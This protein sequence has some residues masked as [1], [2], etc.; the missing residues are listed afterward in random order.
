M[1]AFLRKM[2]LF[3]LFIAGVGNGAGTAAVG[4][5]V[6]VTVTN[7]HTRAYIEGVKVKGNGKKGTSKVRGADR[8]DSTFT[9]VAVVAHTNQEIRTFEVGGGGAGNVAVNVF[10]RCECSCGGYRRIY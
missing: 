7:N 8:S 6:N 9:G 1:W 4:V 2:R 3:L 5:S 10:R